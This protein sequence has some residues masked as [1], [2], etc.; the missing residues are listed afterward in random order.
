MGRLQV[1]MHAPAAPTEVEGFDERFKGED[2]TWGFRQGLLSS[3]KF[4][5]S[6]WLSH[7]VSSAPGAQRLRYSRHGYGPDWRVKPIQRFW[8]LDSHRPPKDSDRL[9]H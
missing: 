4:L 9:T 2:N 1:A 5:A 8:T 7:G 3:G 6:D